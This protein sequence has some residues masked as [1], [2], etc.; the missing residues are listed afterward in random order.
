MCAIESG[1]IYDFLFLIIRW[2]SLLH[3]KDD[4]G[5]NLLH[6]AAKQDQG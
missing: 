6:I 3:Y 2:P 4:F 1:S 5:N